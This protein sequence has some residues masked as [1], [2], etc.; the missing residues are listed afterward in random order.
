[1]D[2]RSSPLPRIVLILPGLASDGGIQRHNRMLA[3]ELT[4]Y[5]QLR[6]MALETLSLHDPEGW[7]DPALLEQPLVGCAGSK[8][9]F[10][11]CVAAALLR[12]YALCVVGHA[13]FGPLALPFQLM[14]PGAPLV[15][16]TYGVEVWSSRPA[17]QRRAL[18]A[19]C[20]VWT[21]S[22]YTA[23]QLVVAQGVERARIEVMTIP[24]DSGFL[25]GLSAWREAGAVRRRTTLLTVARLSKSEEGK[26]VDQVIA[27]LPAVRA[28]DPELT[29]TIVGDGDDRPR[30]EGLAAAHGVGD[31]VRF[32]GRVADAEL[33]AYLAGAELFVMPSRKEGFGIVFV[34]AMAHGLPVIAGAHG[35]SPEVV[36]HGETG[37]L[38]RNGDVAGLEEAIV[39]LLNDPERR[40]RMGAAGRR[41]AATVYAYERFRSTVTASLDRLLAQRTG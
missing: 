17:M 3:R 19:A 41:R 10:A 21:I 34:E 13:D 16:Q 1:M 20:A 38:V 36:A 23:E 28:L 15:A 4:H 8:A 5:A 7:H 30:L 9:R 37:L 33:H 27:A 25:A 40:R 22:G 35:G 24:L 29:Y 39:A 26:G 2:T 6:G 18:Q 12:P 14:R 32:A 31:V 11:A